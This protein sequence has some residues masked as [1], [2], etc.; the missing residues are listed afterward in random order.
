MQNTMLNY[1]PEFEKLNNSRRDTGEFC[2][3]S[4][5]PELIPMEKFLV[6]RHEY[7]LLSDLLDI[8]NITDKE[9]YTN[10]VSLCNAFY[11]ATPKQLQPKKPAA[12]TELQKQH[13]Y[14]LDGNAELS[15]YACWTLLKEMESDTPTTFFQTYYMMPNATLKY[16]NEATNEI[17]R[18]ALR[19]DV[20]KYQK[21]MAGIMKSFKVK[22]GQ[23]YADLNNLMVR[24]LFGNLNSGDIRNEYNI[25]PNKPLADYMSDKLLR[26]YANAMKNIIDE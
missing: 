17:N 11:G 6:S 19:K 10:D 9:K 2:E 12:M 24:W 1:G 14:K 13:I 4:F 16:L 15:R 20:A 7:W 22:R 25:A 26:T 23:Y 8:V 3:P 5:W 18:I 21:Q